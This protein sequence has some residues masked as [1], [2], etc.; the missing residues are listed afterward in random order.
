MT[1]PNDL[2]FINDFIQMKTIVNERLNLL[3]VFK[4]F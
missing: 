1:L 3:N 2:N 4:S